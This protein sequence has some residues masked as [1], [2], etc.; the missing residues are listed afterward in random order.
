MVQQTQLGQGLDQDQNHHQPGRLTS[1]A[2][3]VTT[4]GNF[5]NSARA[6]GSGDLATVVEFAPF[7]SISRLWMDS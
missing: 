7:Y 3:T 2:S 1:S 5:T 4:A 6:R